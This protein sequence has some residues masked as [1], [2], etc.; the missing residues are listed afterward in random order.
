MS[1]PKIRC[2][3]Y[4][5]KSTEEGLDQ[6]F[7][8][9]DAQHE[10]CA[11]YIASQK[12]E[13]WKMLPAR[14]DDGGISGGT[15][16]RPALQQ[17]MADIDAGRV[18]MVVVYKIDRLTRSL[19]D[20][21]KLVERLEKA[22]CSFVSVTQA[23]NTSSSM[24][25]LTLNVLLSFAQ[26]EREVT[27][28]RIRD[29]IAAS[30][31]K[32]LWMG[33]IPPLGYD[34]HPDKTR[35]ELVPNAQEAD[36]VRQIFQLYETHRCLNAVVRTAEELGI[37]SKHHV[38][39]TGRTQGGTPFSRGQIYHLLTNP[40][41]LGLIRHKDQ[42]FDGQHP[43]IIDQPLW[44]SVQ[45]HLKSASARR[46]GAPAGQS[47][48][49]DAPLKGKVR[50][51][52]GDVLTPTHT[53]RHGKRQRYY[54]SNR[55]ISGS[56]DPTGWRLPA[57]GFETAVV[58]AIAD[59]LREHA[60]RHTV[61]DNC[62]VT[63]LDAAAKAVF[64]LADT[65][66]AD[67]C[68]RTAPLIRAIALD[69]D[70]LSIDLDPHAVAGAIDLQA[71]SLNP[72]FCEISTPF[73]CKR[74]GVETRIVAGDRCPDPD[75][76]LI[77]GLRN[78]HDWAEALKSGEPLKHLAQRIGHSER[79]IRRVTSLISLSPGLQTAILEG[80]QPAHLNLENLVRGNI[81]LNWAHQDR[82]FGAVS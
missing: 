50:D 51:E 15:L 60:K 80:T 70:T 59:H 36:V 75:Q 38:F 47:S 57:K 68:K 22:D 3:I 54:V 73:T 67:G 12:H 44:D 72:A 16:E 82:L 79:Y 43:A 74:R 20:F 46:R 13:G 66:V 53:T 10:A 1:S 30:K 78:A 31:K 39:A 42:T 76:T 24:G 21:A 26:F 28:E 23:F 56:A 35:R 64:G 4:T 32:G 18:D 14:Y 45:R 71:S 2:A 49:S 40:V 7:N 5:R 62:D 48:N 25:R 65:L 6:D 19:A 61:L 11:A 34:P 29:K 81:P 27:A 41:Y 77:R 55:L 58:K 69:P 17:L 33:G 63:K 9:L 37:R 52:T 8:S